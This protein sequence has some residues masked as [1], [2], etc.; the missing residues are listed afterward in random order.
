MKMG[1]LIDN[2]DGKCQKPQNQKWGFY[3]LSKENFFKLQL[4]M[5]LSVLVPYLWA[6]NKTSLN[7]FLLWHSSDGLMSKQADRQDS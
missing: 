4:S 7:H 3:P 2:Y 6:K 5:I 1:K